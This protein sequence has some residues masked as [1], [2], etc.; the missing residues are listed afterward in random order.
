MTTLRVSKH[1]FTV[2][3][4]DPSIQ[5]SR[6]IVDTVT[7][8]S[9]LLPGHSWGGGVEVGGQGG[10]AAS[11]RGPGMGAGKSTF[12]NQFL[13]RHVSW[14]PAAVAASTLGSAGL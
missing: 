5:I 12:C 7:R 2:E 1:H 11:A 6:Y 14:L 10:G 8:Q 4:K 3:E 13:P 9:P